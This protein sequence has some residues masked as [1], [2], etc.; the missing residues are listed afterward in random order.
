MKL[1]AANSIQFDEEMIEF[2]NAKIGR[3]I[4]ARIKDLNIS[5]YRKGYVDHKIYP[6]NH[7]VLLKT[8]QPEGTR[9]R[10]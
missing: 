5:H 10:K 4:Q 6:G 1:F 7:A 8:I 3:W 9:E 2:M